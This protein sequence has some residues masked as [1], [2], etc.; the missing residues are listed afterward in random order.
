MTAKLTNRQQLFIEHYLIHLNAAK[1]ARLAGYTRASNVAG[2]ELLHHPLISKLI[3][4]RLQKDLF[5]KSEI[6]SKLSKMS[7]AKVTDL[8]SVDK[9]GR[10]FLDPHKLS[11][12]ESLLGVKKI[13]M[14]GSTVTITMMDTSR[15]LFLVAKLSGY[16][17]TENEQL[18]SNNSSGLGELMLRHIQSKSNQSF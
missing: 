17:S 8:V 1:A 5:T 4:E 7:E 16:L 18:H 9:D 11:D 10:L 13:V 14:R 15:I 6:I 12:P 2:S 3:Q